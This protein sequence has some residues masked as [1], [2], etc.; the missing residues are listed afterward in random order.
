M[1]ESYKIIIIAMILTIV[2]FGSALSTTVAESNTN[3]AT[4]KQL[5]EIVIMQ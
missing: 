3:S 1:R 5:K 4:E 2:A